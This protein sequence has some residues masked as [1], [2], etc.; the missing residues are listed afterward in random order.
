MKKLFL[1]LAVLFLFS[2]IF[3]S[4]S[5]DL[6]LTLKKDGS[7][8]IAFA[9]GTGEAFTKMILAAAGSQ[10]G[11]GAQGTKTIDVKQVSYELAKAG[12]SNVKADAKSASDIRITMSDLKKSSYIFTSGL[13]K[14]E[15]KQLKLNITKQVLIDFYDSADEQTKMILDLFLAPVFNDEEMSQSEY[16]E[17]LGTFYGQDSANE[18]ENSYVTITLIDLEGKNQS[19]KIP[20]SQIMCGE[21]AN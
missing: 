9:G 10:S 5:V 16:I 8:D 13:V 18:V 19:Q 4:C 17:M 12:F 15:N 11:Q 3:T 1:Y 21:F 6:K 2:V 14:A 20:M 7:V